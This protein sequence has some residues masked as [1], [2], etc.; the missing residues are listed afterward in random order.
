MKTENCFSIVFAKSAALDLMS[1]YNYI[2]EESSSKAV[3]IIQK[4]ESK[5]NKLIIL[6]EQGRVVPELEKFNV[7]I[8]REIIE[9]PWRI[10]YKDELNTILI[11]VILDGRRNIEDLLMQR[12]L[13]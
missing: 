9:N 6:P 8:Y 1:I 3:K 7:L 10:I 4:L 5:I 13:R 11:I 2:A 12:L